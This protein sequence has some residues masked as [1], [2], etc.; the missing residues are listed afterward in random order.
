M[1]MEQMHSEAN[2]NLGADFIM[3]IRLGIIKQVL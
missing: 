2:K 3:L 1:K